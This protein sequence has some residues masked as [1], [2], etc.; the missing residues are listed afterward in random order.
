MRKSML[1]PGEPLGSE[2]LVSLG[3]VWISSG[4]TSDVGITGNQKITRG[5]IVILDTIQVQRNLA[6]CHGAKETN[7]ILQENNLVFFIL[8]LPSIC[9]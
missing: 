4:G 5:N 1:G 8:R 6:V 7:K 3:T 9:S 2:R